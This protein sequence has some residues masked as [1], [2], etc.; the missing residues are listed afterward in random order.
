M[1]KDSTQDLPNVIHID[2][3]RVRDHLGELVRGSMEDTLNC[4]LDAEADQ[5]VGAK[6]YERTD[7][8]R[9]TSPR[10]CGELE[11]AAAPSAS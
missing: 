10:R 7:A 9:D 11:A 8:R 5:L 3:A 1:T 2:E 4:L 6:R